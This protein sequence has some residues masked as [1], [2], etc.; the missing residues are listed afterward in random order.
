MVNCIV[1]HA[2]CEG[3]LYYCVSRRGG[4]KGGPMGPPPFLYDYFTHARL[5]HAKGWHVE[6]KAVDFLAEDKGGGASS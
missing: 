6:A 3:A 1:Y 4:S 2:Y 5:L